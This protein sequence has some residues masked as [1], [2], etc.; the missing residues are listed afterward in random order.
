MENKFH[1][2]NLYLTK[3]RYCIYFLFIQSCYLAVFFLHICLDTVNGSYVGPL[4]EN[5][6]TCNRKYETLFHGVRTNVCSQSRK[7]CI[8]Y[9]YVTECRFVCFNVKTTEP[10]ELFVFRTIC[11]QEDSHIGN[12]FRLRP[13]ALKLQSSSYG[14]Q[15]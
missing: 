7:K 6:V 5:F 2:H 12:P 9:I 11:V 1:I 14:Q 4:K 15:V 8:L 10:I 3:Q 13:S